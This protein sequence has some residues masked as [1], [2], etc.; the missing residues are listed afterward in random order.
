MC[1]GIH[2]AG[3]GGVAVVT[4]ESAAVAVVT[5]GQPHRGLAE[6]ARL[7]GQGPLGVGLCLDTLVNLLAPVALPVRPPDVAV[8]VPGPQLPPGH[9]GVHGAGVLGAGGRRQLVVVRPTPVTAT[10][11]TR[12]LVT[13]TVQRPELVQW[14]LLHEWSEE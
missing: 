9:R 11:A 2:T 1:A 4:V 7:A 3:T 14:E 10:V 12:S 8:H 6:G 13:G 5:P